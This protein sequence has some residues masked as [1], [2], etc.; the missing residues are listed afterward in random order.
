MSD[1]IRRSPSRPMPSVADDKPRPPFPPQP[2]EPPWLEA[3]MTPRPHC[4]G[5]R[6]R[7]AGTLQDKVALITGGDSGIGRSV[8]YLFAREGADVCARLPARGTARCAR[9][10]RGDRAARAAAC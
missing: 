6:Y 8:A 4:G 7:S 10:A 1:D 5:V 9:S 3:E 2:L